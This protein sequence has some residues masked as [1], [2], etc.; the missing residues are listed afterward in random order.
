MLD[1]YGI[2]ISGKNAV[3]LGRS[4]V[5]GKPVSMLLTARNATVTTCHSKTKGAAKTAKNADIVIAALGKAEAVDKRYFS[6]GQT[7]L[8]VGINEGA[9][10]KIIGDVKFTDA[11][12]IVAAVT[13]S[14]GGVG[15]VTTA[16]LISHVVDAAEKRAE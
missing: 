14:P 12:T 4:L 15:S 1:Y 10:G 13:P 2:E 16:V 7:V 9:D 6:K 3:V 11:E 5:I 8:D